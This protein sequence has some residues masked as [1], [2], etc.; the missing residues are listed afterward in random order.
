MYHLQVLLAAR[1]LSLSDV[2]STLKQ[3]H[4]KAANPD[5]QEEAFK[6]GEKQWGK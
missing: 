6:R 3:R 5:T 2:A 4:S 1:N